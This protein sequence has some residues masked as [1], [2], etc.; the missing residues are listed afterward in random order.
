[1]RPLGR[2]DRLQGLRW[3]TVQRQ[4]DGWRYADACKRA[5][6]KEFTVL[7]NSAAGL[8]SGGR[9]RADCATSGSVG[10]A[11]IA[12]GAV[13]GVANERCAA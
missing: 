2:E 4:S 6:E 8:R 11:D 3:R 5:S 1:M 12:T 10:S 9:G 13:E 7:P